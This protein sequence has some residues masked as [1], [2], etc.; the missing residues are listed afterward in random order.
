MDSDINVRNCCQ[1]YDEF[2]MK[3]TTM[4]ITGKNADVSVLSLAGDIFWAVNCW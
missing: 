1:G 2:V 3:T 4:R